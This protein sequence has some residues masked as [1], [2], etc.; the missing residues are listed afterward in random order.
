[1]SIAGL[2]LAALAV[3]LTCGPAF[4]QTLIYT[5]PGVAACPAATARTLSSPKRVVR[6]V[7]VAGS[8]RVACGLDQGSYTVSLGSSDPDA[9]FSPRSFLV[10]FGRVVGSGEFAV[11]FVTPGRQTVFASI[12]SNMGSPPARGRFESAEGEFE[13]ANP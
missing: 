9:D 3:A 11:R 8:I 7:P 2:G 5:E 10:N 13:V 4:A 1:M 6:G 12:T